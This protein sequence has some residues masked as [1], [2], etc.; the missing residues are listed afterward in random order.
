M[1][2]VEPGVNVAFTGTDWMRVGTSLGWRL[3]MRQAWRPPNDFALAGPYLGV[4]V[5]FGWFGK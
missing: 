5:D 2:V 3:V 4:N 1:F